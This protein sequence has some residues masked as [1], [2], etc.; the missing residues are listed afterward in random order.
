MVQAHT[1]TYSAG[2]QESVSQVAGYERDTGFSINPVL[3]EESTQ[4][5]RDTE[6]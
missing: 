4:F 1:L 2:T 6:I 5:L 3:P